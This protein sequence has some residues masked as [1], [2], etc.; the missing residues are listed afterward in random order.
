VVQASGAPV[1]SDDLKSGDDASGHAI[2]IEEGNNADQGFVCTNDSGS[3]TV[4]TDALVWTQFTGLGSVTAGDGLSK[5]GNQI[6]VNVDDATIEITADSLNVKDAG[7]TNAKLANPS[8]DVIAGNALATNAQTI[9]LGGSAQLDVKVDDVGIE[10]SADALQLK[11]LGVVDAKI[12]N[13]TISNAKLA[14]SSLT[15]SA[16]D[17]LQ[18]GGLVSL[19]G[20]ITVDVDATVVRTSGAQSIGGSKT[21][22]DDITMSGTR[23]I[24]FENFALVSDGLNFTLSDT[25]S[26]ISAVDLTS[27]NSGGTV[28][29]MEIN[30]DVAIHDTLQLGSSLSGTQ[31][32]MP[33][34]RGTA[35]QV[36]STNG[37]GVGSWA[38][39]TGGDG[40]DATGLTL[41]VDATVVRTSGNQSV[42]GVKTFSDATQATS[43]TVAG[44]I[45]SGGVGIA[46]DVRIAGDAYAL[47]FNATSDE[48]LKK[49]VKDIKHHEGI[50]KVR[51]VCFKWLDSSKDIHEH[52]GVIAQELEKVYPECVRVDGKGYYSVEY[53]S[54]FA[55][56][57]KSHQELYKEVVRLKEKM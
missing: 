43:S 11:D 13:A 7:I 34:A 22:T 45:F 12:A 36:L 4:G 54:L 16:G 23:S 17:G 41:D 33:M 46:K 48:R 29:A 31:W 38:S 57:L 30:A 52:H 53:Q 6:D 55:I 50:H 9:A 28:P 51:P 2:F 32:S 25:A 26:L 35:N 14:N 10:I 39:I 49:D 20:S 21:F 37:S 47:S 19:G 24:A 15:V 1:R 44:C 56:L 40:I 5:T 18:N 27:A 8:L 42:A 3:A